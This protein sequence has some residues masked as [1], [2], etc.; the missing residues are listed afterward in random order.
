M[1]PHG[2]LCARAAAKSEAEAK[3]DAKVKATESAKARHVWEAAANAFNVRRTASLRQAGRPFEG[4]EAVAAASL[5]NFA[6]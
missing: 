1:P 2:R 3:A 5:R 4:A 6:R